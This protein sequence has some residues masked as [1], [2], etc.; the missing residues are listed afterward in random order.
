MTPETHSALSHRGFPMES[1]NDPDFGCESVIAEIATWLG[2]AAA[3]VLFIFCLLVAGG[4]Y[5][6]G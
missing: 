4:Y 2:V 6:K 1:Q 5:F 3:V